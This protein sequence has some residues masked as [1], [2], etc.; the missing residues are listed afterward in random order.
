MR[1]IIDYFVELITLTF[2]LIKLSGVPGIIVLIVG[3]WFNIC[4]IR[5]ERNFDENGNYKK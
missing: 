1:D 2:E 3:I 4:L 5:S